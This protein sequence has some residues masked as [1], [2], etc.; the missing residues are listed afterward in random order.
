MLFVVCSSFT[1]LLLGEE[2]GVQDDG[3]ESGIRTQL[4]A[5]SP[6]GN[7]ALPWH[8]LPALW[9]SCMSLPQDPYREIPL[10]LSQVL[11]VLCSN[12]T[13]VTAP[14]SLFQASV[15]CPSP[16]GPLCSTTPYVTFLQCLIGSGFSDGFLQETA[17]RWGLIPSHPAAELQPVFYGLHP[18]QP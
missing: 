8:T 18:N 9:A 1:A 4:P 15:Y 5:E 7:E 3:W 13:L 17:I 14:T 2:A 10:P 11:F 16:P 6:C 12:R